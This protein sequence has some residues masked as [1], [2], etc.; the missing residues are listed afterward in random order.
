MD[1]ARFSPSK[2][3]FITPAD[4]EFWTAP[5]AQ[6]AAG[7]ALLDITSELFNWTDHERG[8]NRFQQQG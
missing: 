3:L 5:V 7:T 4:V 2:S 1:A 6:G 8:S